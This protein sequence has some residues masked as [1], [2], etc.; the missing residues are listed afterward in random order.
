MTVTTAVKFPPFGLVEKVTVKV[1]AVAAVTVPTA[2]LLK[3]TVLLPTVV[4]NPNPRIVIVVAVEVMA[5]VLI[6]TVG[7]TEAT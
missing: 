5:A 3:T 4:L 6:V 1:V 2:P 7:I